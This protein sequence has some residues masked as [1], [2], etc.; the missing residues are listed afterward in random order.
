VFRVIQP[1]CVYTSMTPLEFKKLLDKYS[2]GECTKA[3]E[4]IVLQWYNNVDSGE[5]YTLSPEEQ[6]SIQQELWSRIKPSG[7]SSRFAFTPLRKIAASLLIL[8]IAGYGIFFLANRFGDIQTLPISQ[9]L[10]VHSTPFK[11]VK[12]DLD[13]PYAILLDDGSKVTLQPASEI[14]Y[15]EKFANNK[16][17]VFLT[18]E[19]FFQV[20]RDKARPFLVYSKEVVTRVLGTSFTIKAYADEKEVTVA[21]KSGKVS[22]YKREKDKETNRELKAG[23]VILKPNQQAVYNRDKPE[24]IKQLVPV[25]EII[26]P[27]PTLFSM[28]YDGAPVVKI[29]QVLEENYGIDIVFDE[30]LLQDCSL[31]TSM[32][33]EGLYERVRIICEAI[34]AEYDI[35]ESNILIRSQGCH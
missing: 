35:Q 16:R 18:G 3:E 28:Q 14:S 30:A 9:E 31:T 27:T 25:P 12:N 11:L 4:D 24:L 13:K 22:V 21:V 5:K 23:E 29:F 8:L 33:D 15:P 7:K 26:L 34:G 10:K 20:S 6:H 19:A 32:S 1:L 17:E 2:R